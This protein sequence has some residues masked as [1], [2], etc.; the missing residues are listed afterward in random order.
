[1][2]TTET[3]QKRIRVRCFGELQIA[4]PDGTNVVPMFLL[5]RRAALFLYLALRDSSD[6]VP[7][8]ELAEMF[9]PFEASASAE[10]ALDE[11]LFLDGSLRALDE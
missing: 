11:A 6:P 5:P 3:E 8:D 7:R 4:R 1:M 9:W 2:A 10:L